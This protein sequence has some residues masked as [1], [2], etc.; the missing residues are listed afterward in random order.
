MNIRLSTRIV[1]LIGNRVYKIPI[2]RRG[3]LQG[4]NESK[5]WKIYKDKG[6]LAPLHWEFCGVVCQER[7][8]PILSLSENGK[9]MVRKVKQIIPQLDINNCDLYNPQN[10]GNLKNRLVL[11]DYG[12]DE[13]IAKL[14]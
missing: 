4:K 8:Q 2:D 1:F 5:L 10:W 11:L 9:N 12:I 13:H 6:I 3:W 14:Y 7:C